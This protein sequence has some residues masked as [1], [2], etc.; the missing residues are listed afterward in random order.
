MHLYL[1][2]HGKAENVG[3]DGRDASRR[4]TPEGRSEWE[5]AA[6]GLG[7]IGARFDA[8]LT[9]PLARARETAEIL[10]AV[11]GGPSPSL[12]PEAAPGGADET[13]LL[14]RL[15]GRG[16]VALVGHQPTLGLLVSIAVF[17]HPTEGTPLGKGEVV[18]LRSPKH[19]APGRA[20]LLWWLTPAV[21]RRV[22]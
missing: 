14:Q 21:L 8:L 16:D 2:R 5:R 22:V 4:L 1:I 3:P 20:V 10:A 12:L 7:R 9:S 6:E 15:G 13:D 19:P 11:L 17:G 18:C